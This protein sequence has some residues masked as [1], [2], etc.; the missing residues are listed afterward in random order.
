[1]GRKGNEKKKERNSTRQ[2]SS[3]TYAK[4]R[5]ATSCVEH[6]YALH[7]SPDIYTDKRAIRMR[8]A[9]FHS[10]AE[11]GGIASLD[12]PRAFRLGP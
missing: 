12:K 5:A 3:P 8:K 6:L 10:T 1:M 7:V 11:V 4:G 9:G 2:R